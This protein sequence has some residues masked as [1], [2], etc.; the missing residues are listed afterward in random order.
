MNRIF[1]VEKA[2]VEDVVA[3]EHI[4]TII[5]EEHKMED[6]GNFGGE[7]VIEGLSEQHTSP[8]IK[9][10][11]PDHKRKEKIASELFADSDDEVNQKIFFHNFCVKP[12]F[13][14]SSSSSQNLRLHTFAKKTQIWSCS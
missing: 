13:H 1:F 4:E 3:E 8:R 2:K 12:V 6:D 5:A 9:R 10:R 11:L 14:I 7:E